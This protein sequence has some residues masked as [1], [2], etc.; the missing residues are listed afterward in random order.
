MLA[1][2]VRALECGAVRAQFFQP[3]E[4][5]RR[6][7]TTFYC[8]E[9]ELPDGGEVADYLHPEW[10]N[11]RFV[12]GAV[13][14]AESR[15]GTRLTSPSFFATGPSR[16]A[17]RFTVGPSWR[18]WGIGFLPLGWA[19]YMSTAACELADAVVDGAEHPAFAGFTALAKDL[20][21]PS[22]DPEAELERI[23]HFFLERDVGP[24]PD[25]ARIVSIHTALV[26]PAV[27]TVCELVA[28]VNASQRTVERTCER[29]FGFSPKVML[30]R[31]RFLRSLAHYA[32]DPTLKWIGALDE[33]YYDQAQFVRDFKEFMGMS[34]R[35]YA[36]L[37]KP[38]LSAV[39]RARAQL[40][41][42]AV[43]A[44]DNPRGGGY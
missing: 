20:F 5:L 2:P 4:Q 6:Y 11:L 35:Q 38:I 28:R 7:F 18:L 40:G 33:Q 29:Y 3:P 19:R 42:K 14:T 10:A 9:T 44:L 26:D 36:A 22:P 12:Q 21:G 41:G 24:I 13:A 25:E 37:D 1:R 27:T 39:M 34:P 43:Q 16:R 8:I 32:A 30:R 23:S 15:D 31:Q 17:V